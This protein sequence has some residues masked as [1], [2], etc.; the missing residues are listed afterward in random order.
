[1]PPIILWLYIPWCASYTNRPIF[2]FIVCNEFTIRRS[3]GMPCLIPGLITF[4]CFLVP[5]QHLS[6][7]FL[8][9]RRR[10]EQ[11]KVRT[12]KIRSPLLESHSIQAANAREGGYIEQKTCHSHERF[13]AKFQRNLW[14]HKGEEEYSYHTKITKRLPCIRFKMLA[15]LSCLSVLTQQCLSQA[16]LTSGGEAFFTSRSGSAPPSINNAFVA[17]SKRPFL[18][19]N[20]IIWEESA[21]EKIKLENYLAKRSQFCLSSSGLRTKE[22]ISSTSCHISTFLCWRREKYVR[23]YH[24]IKMDEGKGQRTF[25]CHRVAWSMWVWWSLAYLCCLPV[26]LSGSRWLPPP[27]RAAGIAPTTCR[28]VHSSRSGWPA[29]RRQEILWPWLGAVEHGLAAPER[30]RGWSDNNSPRRSRPT[31]A[32]RTLPW[33]PIGPDARQ[34]L[35]QRVPSSSSIQ[36]YLFIW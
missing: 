8:N 25:A 27:R 26:W 13:L 28:R 6:Y 4:R 20:L 24:S 5:F 35:L 15:F 18:V 14:D 29:T 9:S 12:N 30:L 7:G 31:T 32:E 17:R 10:D 3:P 11:R 21:T 34:H 33:Y 23:R 16:Y 2:V 22:R 1:M 36:D 19:H